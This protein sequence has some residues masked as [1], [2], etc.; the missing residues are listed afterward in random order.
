[1]HERRHPPTSSRA[2]SIAVN[3][4]PQRLRDTYGG[5]DPRDFP[6][7]SCVE[8]AHFAQVPPATL[9]SWVLGRRYEASGDDKWFDRLFT[10]AEAKPLRLSF[11]NLVEAYVLA[12]IRREYG[13]KMPRVRQALEFLERELRVTRPLASQSFQT[14]GIDLFVEHAG[15]LI[16]ASRGGQLASSELLRARLQRIEFD[17][18]GLASRLYPLART[19]LDAAQPRLVVIAPLIAYGRPSIA[20][21]GVPT[22]VVA[23]RFYAG[24]D[25]ESLAR[26]YACTP[27]QIIEAIRC[28]RLAA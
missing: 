25:P 4:T 15:F 22:A 23:Q 28:E 9:R 18:A 14:N 20:G 27:E 16:T 17:H 21:R 7:Y 19:T 26:D 5:R 3:T 2:R 24:E 12:A 13:V 8:V 11:L 6:A 10:P 1:M